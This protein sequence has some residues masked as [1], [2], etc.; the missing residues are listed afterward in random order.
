MNP[1]KNRWANLYPTISARITGP[2]LLMVIIIAAVGVYVVTYLVA[3]SIQER[4]SNQLISSADAATSSIVDIERQQLATLR[5]LVFTQGVDKALETHDTASLDLWLRPIA[6]NAHLDRLLLF[7]RAGQVL[8]H[9]MRDENSGGVQYTLLP[10]TDL[11]AWSGVQQVLQV[12]VD[13]QGD[14]FVDVRAEDTGSVLYISAPVFDDL[15]VLQGGISVG[16]TLSQIARRTYEQALSAV[17]LYE[18]TG[19]VLGTTLQSQ[20]SQLVLDADHA[21]QLLAAAETS[22]PIEKIVLNNEEYQVLY[23]PFQVRSTAIGL[24]GVALPSRFL[25]EQTSTSRDLF[26]LL[27]SGMF[28]VVAVLGIGIGR[29]ITRPVARL[30]ETTRLIRDGDLSQRVG[31]RMPDE[32]G[33]LSVSFDHMTDQLV[34][35]NQEINQLYLA[36][37]QE[38]VRRDAVLSSIAD[39]V[40][41]QN[42]SGKII[43]RNRTADKLLQL[44]QQ[45]RQMR[46]TFIQLCKYPGELAEP[47]T[48]NFGDQF[49]S[50]LATTVLMPDGELL[51]YVIVFRDI[52]VLIENERIKDEMILQLSHEL[53]TPLTAARGYVDLL[54][55]LEQQRLSTQGQGFVE[56]VSTHLHTLERMVNQVIDVSAII[57]HQF[58][59]D[60]EPLDLTELLQ[61]HLQIWEPLLAQRELALSFTLP[62]TLPLTGDARRLGQMIDHLL[63]NAYSYTLPGGIV[64]VEAQANGTAVTMA[65]ID[66]GVG[67]GSHEIDKVF[68]RLYR[69]QSADAGPTD[70]RGLGLGLY[71]AR[72]IVEAH[73]GT[74]RLESQIDV[75]TVVTVQLPVGLKVN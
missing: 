68:E 15:G 74:I 56:N 16:I 27:F 31:L 45:N 69:G 19:G 62:P 24:L 51:G 55:M 30:V 50:V 25:V 14:K 12:Q 20:Q 3:G 33:E 47:R 5:L 67:I 18:K 72:H 63:H 65:V 6:A 44:V 28:A 26:G 4:F 10:T 70:S 29:T 43:L 11:Q 73:Q 39:A 1:V 58:V 2:F 71:L 48:V 8:L 22:S 49:F 40:M 75:G 37:L 60:I 41:V 46:R 59:L 21:A 53:R 35:R 54:N 36:Q 52:T 61:T 34:Q 9:F 7:D 17:T 32:L 57:A 66:S 13:V 38:T 23:V 64:K 42:P